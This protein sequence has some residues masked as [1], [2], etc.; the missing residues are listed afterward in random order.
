MDPYGKASNLGKRR[1][2][3]MVF[4]LTERHGVACHGFAVTGDWMFEFP[5]YSV[6]SLTW[7]KAAAYGK[8]IDIRPEK[9]RVALIHISDHYSART[10]YGT[11]EAL[12]P[13]TRKALQK[14]VESRGFDFD[15]MRKDITYRSLFN[16][17]V[18]VDAV[19]AHTT[20][21]GVWKNWIPLL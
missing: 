7:L 14:S 1:Y 3:D 8:I 9:Q 13:G 20:R 6:D 21:G 16:A 18:F 11:I 2:F 4:N 15:L 5:W 10:A 19:E 17:R 12:A